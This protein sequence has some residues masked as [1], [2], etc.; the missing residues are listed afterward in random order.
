MS[1]SFAEHL[2]VIKMAMS[3]AENK[4]WKTMNSIK[5]ER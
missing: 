1:K 3:V 2:Q 4:T 5:Y